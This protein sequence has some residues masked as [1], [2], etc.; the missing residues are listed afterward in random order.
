MVASAK[1]FK[2]EDRNHCKSSIDTL[3]LKTESDS[4]STEASQLSTIDKSDGA[5]VLPED[6]IK[7]E[8]TPDVTTPLTIET[9][10]SGTS[11]SGPS[12]ESTD[13]ASEVGSGFSS[14]GS[15]QS[16]PHL[17]GEGKHM[18]TQSHTRS[19]SHTHTHSHTHRVAH[20]H[21]H[22]PVLI[23]NTNYLLHLMH[24]FSLYVAEE[25]TG[26]R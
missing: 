16:S 21:T 18:L 8:C 17:Q 3:S 11:S 4:S 10:F 19:Q 2:N 22:T 6:K 9:K 1:D 12:S 20:I 13:T 25:V 24:V 26:T 5:E 14:P 15:S 7:R 23:Y